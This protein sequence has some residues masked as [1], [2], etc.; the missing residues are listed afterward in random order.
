MGQV[1]TAAASDLTQSPPVQL[2]KRAQRHPDPPPVGFVVHP[3]EQHFEEYTVGGAK[4]MISN[5]FAWR[6]RDIDRRLLDFSWPGRN[7]RYCYEHDLTMAPIIDNSLQWIGDTVVGK[8]AQEAGQTIVSND[9]KVWTWPSPYSPIYR[10]ETARYAR[11]VT[12][13][14]MKNDPDRRV[15]AYLNGAE[16]YWHGGFDYS[17]PTLK[18]FRKWLALRYGEIGRLNETWGTQ[19]ARFED[20]QAPRLFRSGNR[21]SQLVTFQVGE[22]WDDASW[23]RKR[24]HDISCQQGDEFEGRVTCRLQ[25]VPESQVDLQGVWVDDKGNNLGWEWSEI[26]PIGN[27]GRYE[28]RWHDIAPQKAVKLWLHLK[29]YGTGTVTFDHWQIRRLQPDP[30]SLIDEDLAQ[31]DTSNWQFVCWTG[32][33]DGKVVNDGS[34]AGGLQI[35]VYPREQPYKRVTAAV[36]DYVEFTWEALADAIDAQAV[37]IKQLDPTRPVA[38]YLGF[39]WALP[40]NWDDAMTNHS[41]DVTISRARSL[42]IIGMQLCSAKG[43]FHYATAT[44][45]VAR[46]ADKPIWATDLI[47]FTHGTHVG[48]AALDQLTQSCIQHGMDG[49][50]WYCWYGTPDYNYYT[51]LKNEEVQALVRNAEDSINE[52]TGRKLVTHVALVN[53]VVPYWLGDPG[54]VK[55]DPFDSYGWHKLLAEMQVTVDV[56]TP[57][58]LAHASPTALTRYSA[59]VLPDASFLPAKAVRLLHGFVEQGGYLIT[60]GGT[61]RWDAHGVALESTLSDLPAKRVLQCEGKVGRDYLGRMKRFRVAGNTP[62]LFIEVE[63]RDQARSR[64]RQIQQQVREFLV[65]AGVQFSLDADEHRVEAALYAGEADTTLFLLRGESMPA[66]IAK[67]AVNISAQSLSVKADHGPWRSI[68]AANGQVV[69]PSFD[70]VCLLRWTH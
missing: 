46:K 33:A 25:G 14:V 48:F 69:L 29:A 51:G 64:G 17:E 59:V 4:T 66:P 70:N 31:T 61:P 53:A 12:Q 63:G 42:D 39:A 10:E 28:I 68:Q 49:V 37:V 58:E 22:C 40:M 9:G 21:T 6:L 19:Y 16:W 7:L 62:P 15:I 45:D 11:Q 3:H 60:S 57:Y 50:F 23:S 55:N 27:D 44:I 41:V 26:V 34:S 47:D 54:G 32:K 18:E 67:L 43:D 36:T 38:S 20:V 24:E 5:V 13:W 35:T 56:W 1:S 65:S 30:K 52:L 8:R 2:D